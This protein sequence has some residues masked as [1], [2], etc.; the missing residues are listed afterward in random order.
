MTP[1]TH[2]VRTMAQIGVVCTVVLSLD[3]QEPDQPQTYFCTITLAP[4]FASVAL[5]IALASLF[6][7][8]PRPYL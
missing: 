5:P 3:T 2:R 4:A 6:E 1:F 8:S 7:I